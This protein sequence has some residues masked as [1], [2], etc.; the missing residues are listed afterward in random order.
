MLH[1][2]QWDDTEVFADLAYVAYLWCEINQ[3]VDK[4]MPAVVRKKLEILRTAEKTGHLRKH[5]PSDARTDRIIFEGYRRIDLRQ[6][7]EVMGERPRF[8][9]P[10]LGDA[11]ASEPNLKEPKTRQSTLH[12]ERCRAIS[13]L[14]W[15]E[16][17]DI[18]IADMIL[19]DDIATHGCENHTYTEG[20]LRG[21]INDL[22][23]NRNPGR[24]PK[25]K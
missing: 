17:A 9:F 2:P 22:A 6:L 12:R 20:V 19:R 21:W 1:P 5:R 8:L 7:A 3:D 15:Q 14:R 25:P 16:D 10:E 18:K 13:A 11:P 24:P 23:P 4:P